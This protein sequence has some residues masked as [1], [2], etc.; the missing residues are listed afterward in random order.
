MQ[1]SVSEI[2]IKADNEPTAEA[3][4]ELLRKHVNNQGVITM[5]KLAYDPQF[6]FN[7]PVGTPPYKPCQFL[8]QEAMLYNNLR[9]MYLWLGEG[10]PG[11]PK[12]KRE[13]LFINLLESLDPNDAILL[14]A[15][16]DKHLP[17]KNLTPDFIKEVFPGL[18]PDEVAKPILETVED[19]PP[20]KRGPGRPKKK[21]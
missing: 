19:A 2:L 18:L 14:I 9:R 16:K 1:L 17:Y 4:K 10:N 20:V 15:V 8:D 6:V 7:L 5:L 12:A 11:I 3:R 21:V 13:A